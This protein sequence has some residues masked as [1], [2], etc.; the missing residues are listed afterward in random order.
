[1]EIVSQF[2]LRFIPLRITCIVPLF[3]FLGVVPVFVGARSRGRC[4][5]SNERKT[6]AQGIPGCFEAI[7]IGLSRHVTTCY[8]RGG[9]GYTPPLRA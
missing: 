8:P 9:V 2:L 7:L 1:M 4:C 6:T 5:P 3:L